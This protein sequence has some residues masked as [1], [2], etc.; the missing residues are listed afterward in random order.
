MTP[1]ILERSVPFPAFVRAVNVVTAL[2]GLAA[3]FLLGIYLIIAGI[4]L[5]WLVG[6]PLLALLAV[7]LLYWGCGGYGA[8]FT[9]FE[10]F[11]LP[12]L[13]F[14][15]FLMGLLLTAG[16]RFYAKT[17]PLPADHPQWHATAATAMVTFPA[18]SLLSHL[19]SLTAI[20]VCRKSSSRFRP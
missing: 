14:Q 7:V 18:L 12:K 13:I 2:T 1:P 9:L 15:T 11:P 10:R 20:L 16:I 3:S 5:I 4:G 8:A 17:H 6:P 19:F